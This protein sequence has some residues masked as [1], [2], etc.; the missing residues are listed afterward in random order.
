MD[1]FTL[2]LIALLAAAAGC[3]AALLW[4]RSQPV[5]RSA[6]VSELEAQLV[7]AREQ[8]IRS[9]VQAAELEREATTL[10]SQLLETALSRPVGLSFVPLLQ[11]IQAEGHELGLHG[12]MDHV[13]WSRRFATGRAPPRT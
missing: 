3:A 12:G 8:A 11:A 13:V 2:I 9:S 6:R 1:S 10:R 4:R 7:A 5:D